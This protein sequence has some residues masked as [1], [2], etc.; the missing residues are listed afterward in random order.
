MSSLTSSKNFT[1]LPHVLPQILRTFPSSRMD[2]LL[3]LPVHTEVKGKS[4]LSG[5][6]L[7]T[8]T[9]LPGQFN[10]VSS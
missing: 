7:I 3:V 6:E 9:I 10:E 2:R 1:V 4:G 5:A 8:L